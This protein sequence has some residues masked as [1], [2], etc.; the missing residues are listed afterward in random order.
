MY[1]VKG[2]GRDGQGKEEREAGEEEEEVEELK[3]ALPAS[4]GA[5]HPCSSAALVASVP[6]LLFWC[7]LC[8][9]WDFVDAITKKSNSKHSS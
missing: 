4:L 8:S 1:N 3:E 2:M 9:M 7:V 5:S 6:A